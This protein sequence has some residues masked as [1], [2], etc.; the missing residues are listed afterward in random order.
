MPLSNDAIWAPTHQLLYTRSRVIRLA[1]FVSRLDGDP[2]SIVQVYNYGIGRLV[3]QK[4]AEPDPSTTDFAAAALLLQ[5]V[6]DAIIEMVMNQHPATTNAE[7]RNP[8]KDEI[9]HGLLRG[10]YSNE[11]KNYLENQEFWM[12]RG[13]VLESLWTDPTTKNHFEGTSAPVFRKVTR[14]ECPVMDIHVEKIMEM[15]LKYIYHIDS[16]VQ[17]TLQDLTEMKHD[18]KITR[19][20]NF[21]VGLSRRSDV[22][23]MSFVEGYPSEITPYRNGASV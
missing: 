11:A 15:D 18:F 10:M 4:V 21:M 1:M 17:P 7:I 6:T 5:S 20:P 16:Y 9:R 12:T 3:E 14:E 8:T 2:K 13:F 23:M 22:P 19:F